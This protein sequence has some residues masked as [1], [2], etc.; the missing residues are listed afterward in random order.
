[1]INNTNLYNLSNYDEQ[2]EK[3]LKDVESCKELCFTLVL[4]TKNDEEYDDFEKV[5]SENWV[6]PVILMN[7]EMFSKSMN[8]DVKH[9]PEVGMEGL[10]FFLT[11]PP[12]DDNDRLII[13]EYIERMQ[14]IMKNYKISLENFKKTLDNN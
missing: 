8:P 7:N 11:I 3:F 12:K 2:F 10:K 4:L 9:L 6:K 13:L 14:P 5:H 1:M